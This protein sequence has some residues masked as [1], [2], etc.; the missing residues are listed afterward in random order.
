MD[1]DLDFRDLDDDERRHVL[2]AISAG[3]NFYGYIPEKGFAF[4]AQNYQA[5]ARLG[6]LEEVWLTA[7]LHTSHFNDFGLDKVKAVFDACDRSRLQS[8]GVS[9][10]SEGPTR[11]T[12]F[13]G[14]AGP[15]HTFGM[16]WNSSLDKAIWYAAHHM[17]WYDLD[18]PAVYVAV[19]D[20]ESIYCRLGH[21]EDEYIAHFDGAWRIDVPRTE[22]RLDRPR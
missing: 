9:L 14:C 22:F 4:I 11:L 7:Y 2:E 1:R 8:Q 15:I 19:V 13:R 5:L 18:H 12:L 10:S 20:Q 21:Y 6:M 17:S 16:S 3:E